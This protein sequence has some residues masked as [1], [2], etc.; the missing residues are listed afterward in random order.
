MI[1][2]LKKLLFVYCIIIFSVFGTGYI[3]V[4]LATLGLIPPPPIDWKDK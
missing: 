2:I 1:N 3:L 4:G